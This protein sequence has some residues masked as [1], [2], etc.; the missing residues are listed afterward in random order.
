MSPAAQAC[1][2]ATQGATSSIAAWRPG[3][4]FGGSLDVV[5]CRRG[6]RPDPRGPQAASAE[7]PARP[8]QHRAARRRLAAGGIAHSVGGRR[9]V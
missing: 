2:C 5:R 7:H 6:H 4:A 1:S 8:R 3:A 9:A